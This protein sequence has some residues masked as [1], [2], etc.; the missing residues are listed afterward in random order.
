MAYGAY[1]AY[2]QYRMD[3]TVHIIGVDG[4]EGE[5]EGLNLVERGILDATIQTPDFGGLSYEIAK[6]I[7]NGEKVDRNIIIQP[8]LIF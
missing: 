2:Q 1:L 7:L 4:F 8:K 5:S 3:G 6:K